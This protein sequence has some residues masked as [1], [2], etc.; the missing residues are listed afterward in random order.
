MHMVTLAPGIEIT[1]AADDPLV[2]RR[3]EITRDMLREGIRGLSQLERDALR[4][5]T[6]DRLLAPD[7]AA[8]LSVDVEIVTASLRSALL[9]L[10]QSLLNQLGEA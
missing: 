10:R 9:N 4:L 5:S 8:T 1:P 7:A 3:S 2:L 6:R